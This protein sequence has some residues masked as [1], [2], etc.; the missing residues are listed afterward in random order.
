VCPV[1][2]PQQP[3]GLPVIAG[4][5]HG[6]HLGSSHARSTFMSAIVC[7]LVIT[8]CVSSIRIV[9]GL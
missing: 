6:S 7:L 5:V 2:L 1:R 4:G 9:K 3:T 8:L